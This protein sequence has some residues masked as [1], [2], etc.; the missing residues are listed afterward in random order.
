MRNN[1]LGHNFRGKCE[2]WGW[3][4]GAPIKIRRQRDV[5]GM[6]EKKWRNERLTWDCAAA[7]QLCITTCCI[8]VAADGN[9]WPFLG[10][11]VIRPL[12]EF[13]TTLGLFWWLLPKI[14]GL[15]EKNSDSPP[16]QKGESG[17]ELGPSCGCATSEHTKNTEKQKKPGKLI[18]ELA[19]LKPTQ[20]AEGTAD[21]LEVAE[22]V[23]VGVVVP[24]NVWEFVRVG[25]SDVLAVPPVIGAGGG[26][27]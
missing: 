27:F 14:C 2:H 6:A 17:L 16:A 25:L 13:L 7:Q 22:G 23:R 11:L 3:R 24:L 21:T 4:C 20:C 5:W 10:H 1:F 19:Y 26:L 18:V 12:L 15:L 8:T 9:T